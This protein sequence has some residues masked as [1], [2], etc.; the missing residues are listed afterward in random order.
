MISCRLKIHGNF[1]PRI[2]DLEAFILEFMPSHPDIITAPI[3]QKRFRQTVSG[4]ISSA[5]SQVI[6]N[7]KI[8]ILDN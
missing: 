3:L 5:I 6:Y 1:I 4:L 8:P 7:H 2:V